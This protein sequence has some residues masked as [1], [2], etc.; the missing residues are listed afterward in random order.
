MIKLQQD[1]EIPINKSQE[2]CPGT[3]FMKMHGCWYRLLQLP[4]IRAYLILEYT[5][6]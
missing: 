3:T 5:H 4:I 2:I 1:E 6:N